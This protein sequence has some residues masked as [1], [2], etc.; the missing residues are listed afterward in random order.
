M[1]TIDL[2]GFLVAIERRKV[3]LGVDE[4]A[5]AVDAR[6]NTGARR[7]AAKRDA[8]RRAEDRALASGVAPVPSCY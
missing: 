7:T 8:L 3:V 5:G 1:R 2:D 6:R 4:S